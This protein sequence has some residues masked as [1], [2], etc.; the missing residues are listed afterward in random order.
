MIL[1]AYFICNELKNTSE[2]GFKQKLRCMLCKSILKPWFSE[3]ILSHP[4]ERRED[5]MRKTWKGGSPRKRGQLQ[6]LQPLFCLSTKISIGTGSC[7][8]L[9]RTARRSCGPYQS[10]KA[11]A[12]FFKA[13]SQAA[14]IHFNRRGILIF[15]SFIYFFKALGAL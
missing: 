14:T 3:W 5:E 4:G 13:W 12:V 15:F 1:W 10:G 6:I 11:K 7:S 8:G 2:S 9:T